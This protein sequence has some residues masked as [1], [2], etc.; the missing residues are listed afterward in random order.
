VLTEPAAT[1]LPAARPACRSCGTAL[2]T[3]VVDL[4]M[5]PLCERFLS[6]DQLDA[7]EPF[8]PLTVFVCDACL[9]V[10]LPEHVSPAEIFTEYAYFSSYS[11]S[12]V[13]HGRRY[14]ERLIRDLELGPGRLVVEV[15]SNDGYLLSHFAAAGVPVLGIEPARNVAAVAIN[16]GIPTIDRFFGRTL[17][18]ELVDEGRRADLLI[19][20]NVLAQ[21]PD[22]HDF[23]GGLAALLAPDG[24]L[25]LEFPHLLRLFEG[26][27]FDTI[28]HEHYSYFSLASA[29]D[30][31]GRHDLL[32]V[33]VE[34][35]P[36]HGGSLRL[37]VRHRDAGN[38]VSPAVER[39]LAMEASAGL[40]SPAT[41]R[42]FGDRIE[43][44][45]RDV[46]EFL[47]GE[48][49]AGRTVAGYGAPGKANTFLNYCGIRTDLVAYTVDRNPF[50]HG[51]FTPGTHIPIHAPE[52]LAETRPDVIWI[53]PW[54][55]A[56]EI[57]AQLAAACD[58]GPR[59]IVAIPE[60]HE[61]R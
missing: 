27:Q 38:S 13:E 37:H 39:I 42:A 52:R 16:R 55:L 24:L 20:N 7:M 8:Y 50:K 44:V 25:T 45:K 56:D 57:A 22:L 60:L 59:L 28:Y 41:Y 35:L 51:R 1:T 40:R 23:V 3:V 21:V 15:A 18:A 54:N 6:T 47:I 2:E 49:R 46:L 31:L 33:D 11:D 34:E 14:A 5:S 53:L 61:V 36:T 10:Q 17:A 30:V 4:G 48:R 32:V 43:A 29:A 26:N 12:W 9:L 19:G 58:W